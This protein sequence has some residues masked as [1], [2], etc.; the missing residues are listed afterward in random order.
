M[1]TSTWPQIGDW[2]GSRRVVWWTTTDVSNANA[3]PIACCSVKR[4]S[5]Q[6][7]T[8]VANVI[9]QANSY[10]VHPGKFRNWSNILDYQW[11]MIVVSVFGIRCDGSCRFSNI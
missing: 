3:N 4:D 8:N 9:G 2:F 6:H 11:V 10:R 5:H 7:V 1:K